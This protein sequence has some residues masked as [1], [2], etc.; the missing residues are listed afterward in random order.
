M[1]K[2]LTAVRIP[3][4]LIDQLRAIA[5]KPGQFYS[6]RSASW[7]IVQAVREFV[8]R[9]QKGSLDPFDGLDDKQ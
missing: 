7:L 3:G 1:A 8:E 4:A 6:D 9:Q 2:D 5:A